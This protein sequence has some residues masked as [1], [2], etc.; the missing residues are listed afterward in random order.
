ME[1]LRMNF[2]SLPKMLDENIKIMDASKSIKEVF[3]Q[4]KKEVDNLL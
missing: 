1:K 2:L 4:I 3:E